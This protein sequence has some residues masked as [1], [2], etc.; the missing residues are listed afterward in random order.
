MQQST[1]SALIATG[2]WKLGWTLEPLVAT[3]AFV[4]FTRLFRF[5]EQRASH[6]MFAAPHH[7][8]IRGAGSLVSYWL[9]VALW[10]TVVPK[11][12]GAPIG[13]PT[14]AADAV[15]LALE[16]CCGIFFYDFI[17][18]WLHLLMHTS[19]TVA[20][21]AHHEQHHKYA[22]DE[23]GFRT[24]NHSL[25]DGTFQVLV[26]ILVQRHTPWGAPKS[27]LARLLHNVI[28][29]EVLV[30]S[31]TSS[32]RPRIARRLF[33]GVDRHCQHHRN[34]GGPPYQQLFGHL[35]AALA[36]WQERRR[37]REQGKTR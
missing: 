11:P 34:G 18:F 13:C 24:V 26:N 32:A 37:R 2:S 10:V 22:A 25:I 21:L 36:W 16:V 5:G 8:T 9:G 23:S 28:L 35:D 4:I 19:S 30:E 33:A 1:C 15:R 17:F 7:F 29:I 31:H 6:S 14:D 3:M 20:W 27:L 12:V